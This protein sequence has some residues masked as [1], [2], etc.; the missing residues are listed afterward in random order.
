MPETTN[1]WLN[2]DHHRTALGVYML[3]VLAHWAEHLVQAYQIWV[4]NMPRPQSRGVLGQFYPWLVTSEWMHYL[5]ALIMLVGL[6]LLRPAFVG[7]AR[8][9]WTVA[10]AIQAW[11]HLEHLLLLIQAQIHHNFWG[12]PV[13]T[14]ILQLIYPRVEV[15]LFYNS[16]VF[17]PMLIAMYLHL[18]PNEKELERTYCDCVRTDARLITAGA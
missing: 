12:Q 15:H 2:R 10:L 8:I 7:R 13:P 18:R 5:Y 4:L 14:S 9:W 3:I 17:L 6:V 11:H 16:V 1:R